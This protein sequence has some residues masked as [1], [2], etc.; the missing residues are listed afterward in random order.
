M[1]ESDT[2]YRISRKRLKKNDVN[3][4]RFSK[5]LK[6]N[7]NNNIA[8]IKKLHKSTLWNETHDLI[9]KCQ[10]VLNKLSFLQ[11]V[12]C[13]EVINNYIAT[14]QTNKNDKIKCIFNYCRDCFEN[15]ETDCCRFLGWRK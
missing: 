12:R 6:L 10:N 13:S 7:D 8:S 3:N 4:D 14:N 2:I 15:E 11:N 5:Y 9:V 1:V